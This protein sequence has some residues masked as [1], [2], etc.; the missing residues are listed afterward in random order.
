MSAIRPVLF[1]ARGRMTADECAF[2]SRLDDAFQ[3][4]GSRLALVTHHTPAT[5]LESHHAVV[6]NGLES[7][8]QCA[9]QATHVDFS[10]MDRSVLLARE[11]MWRGLPRSDMHAKLRERGIDHAVVLYSHLLDE[12]EPE[13]CVIWN[14]QHP[15]EMILAAQCVRRGIPIVHLE[16]GPFPGT[17]HPDHDGVLGASSVAS[18]QTWPQ[19]DNMA[20]A[21][22]DRAARHLNAGTNTWWEQPDPLGPRGIRRALGIPKNAR[23]ALFFGQVDEDAQNILHAPG[24]ASNLEAFESWLQTVPREGWFV[25][26]KHHPKSS[27]APER[28][29]AALRNAHVCGAWTNDVSL[30]D[31][32]CV[33][34]RATA[35]NSSALYESLLVGLPV[36][37]LGRSILSKK[38]IAFGID[39]PFFEFGAHE[40]EERAERWRSF[41]AWFL[42]SSLC[43]M[44]PRLSNL[45]VPGP[46]LIA[47]MAMGQYR[48][49]KWTA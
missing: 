3:A 32:L 45:G 2:H 17:L 46:A 48:R 35:V 5:A 23:V 11:I 13:S 28:Y 44:D 25:L 39:D 37:L 22:F 18:M 30:I 43:A 19:P 29:A 21:V 27:V 8:G 49:L 6:P 24:F 42:S 14:G 20:L 34:N 31:A 40:H 10:D 38:G 1:H 41:G 4:R 16:R 47:D 33:A 26:G 15:Q 9:P 7:L 12:L 36:Q